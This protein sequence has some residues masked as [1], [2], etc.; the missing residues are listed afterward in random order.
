VVEDDLLDNALALVTPFLA[1]LAAE[2]IHASGVLAVVVTGLYLG[3]R[4]PALMSA[5]SRLVSHSLWRMIE[6]LLQGIVF[7]LIGLQLPGLLRGLGGYPGGVVAVATVAVLATVIVGRFVWV[8]PAT[9]LTRLIRRVRERDPAP[10][11]QVPAVISWAGLRG[12]VSMAAAFALPLTTADGAAF[13]QRDLLLFVTFM[14]VLVTL[15]LQGL[16]L[17]WAIRRLRLPGPDPIEDALQEAE[18]QQAA[19][20]AALARLDELVAEDPPPPGVAE[21]LRDGAEERRFAA[22]ER[23][24]AERTGAGQYVTPSAAHRRLRQ[25]MIQAERDEF[26]R[27]RDRGELDDEILRQVNRRLD[28]EEA[29]LM[30]DDGERQDESIRAVG[31]AGG[32]QR[33]PKPGCEHVAQV[34]ED[35]EPGT[36]AG[37]AECLRSGDHWVHLRL[38]MS[39]G[40]VGC[41]DSSPNRHAT[42][43]FHAS[44]HPIVRSFEP[45]EAWRWCYVDELLV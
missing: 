5:S 26:V 10:P 11:W 23:L 7:V 42:A 2:A 39:C 37:C 20:G 1:F 45:G 22:W 30:R 28:L 12:V 19:A 31:G 41:C 40:H 4:E 43:H 44:D 3:H 38:C 15:V 13:P 18:A 27:R 6:F 17:P 24:G 9:Y 36:P 21:A 29:A 33:R 32:A 25:A 16:T 14:V 8:F 34:R 35:V